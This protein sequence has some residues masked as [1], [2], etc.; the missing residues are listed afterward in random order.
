MILS[1]KIYLSARV[2]MKHKHKFIFD[3]I[4]WNK[5]CE[6]LNSIYYHH[7]ERS[8]V[9]AFYDLYIFSVATGGYRELHSHTYSFLIQV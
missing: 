4:L 6:V 1:L 2:A 5:K 8:T 3:V 7:V 9:I